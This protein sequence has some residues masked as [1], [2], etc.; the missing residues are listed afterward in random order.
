MNDLVNLKLTEKI[1]MYADDISL[2]YQY[3]NKTHLKDYME[4]DSALIL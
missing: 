1:I 4:R 2:F 3:K